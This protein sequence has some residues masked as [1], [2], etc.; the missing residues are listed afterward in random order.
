MAPML[1]RVRSAL[2]SL[3]LEKKRALICGPTLPQALLA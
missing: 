1:V 3:A 2:V